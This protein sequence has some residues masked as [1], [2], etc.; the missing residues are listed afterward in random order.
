GACKYGRWYVASERLRGLQVD[1]QLVLGRGLHRKVGGLFAFEDTIDI[2]GRAA[3]LVEEIRPVGYQP[4]SGD[5]EAFEVDRRQFV[6]RRQR[7]D[8]IAMNIGQR[9]ARHDQATI[10]GARE[11][12]DGALDLAGVARVERAHLQTE[13]RR[14]CLYGPPLPNSAR[15]RG[16]AKDPRPRHARRNFF[17]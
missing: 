12:R 8:Q 9:A 10:R 4:A 6:T 13:R 11:R 16:I 3:I 14:R 7:D 1:G 17:E 2:A 5:E 15:Y